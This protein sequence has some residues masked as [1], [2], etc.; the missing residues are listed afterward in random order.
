MV[1][2]LSLKCCSQSALVWSLV[3]LLLVRI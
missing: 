1:W 2:M 3:N